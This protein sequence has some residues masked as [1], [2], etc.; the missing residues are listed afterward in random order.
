[1]RKEF[2]DA[3]EANDLDRMKSQKIPNIDIINEALIDA[4]C[5]GYI[6]I[7]EYLYNI[8]ADIS[9]GSYSA[10]V[11]ACRFDN[12]E[13]AEWLYELGSEIEHS[14][15]SEVCYAGNM[16]IAKWLYELD[17]NILDSKSFIDACSGG[18]LHIVQWLYSLDPTIISSDALIRAC[19][20]SNIDLV[21]WLIDIHYK[22]EQHI[23]FYDYSRFLLEIKELLIEANLVHPRQLNN[24][25]LEHYLE[26]TDGLVPADFNHPN[27]RKRGQRTKPA[28][29]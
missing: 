7:A 3:C 18:H 23:Y 13:I 1:M 17:A 4:C 12:F 20:S 15:F 24:A 14:A 8:G 6:E 2:L 26:C 28:P 19:L 9:Q 21:K 22:H 5:Y 11:V 29:K 25:D 27:T 16:Y 10:F